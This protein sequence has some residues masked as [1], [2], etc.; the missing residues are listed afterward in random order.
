MNDRPHQKQRQ[1]KYFWIAFWLTLAVLV[2]LYTWAQMRVGKLVKTESGEIL[3]SGTYARNWE[4][5]LPKLIADMEDYFG[6]AGAEISGQIDT[7]IDAAFAPVYRQIPKFAD[8][9]YSVT[10]EY[11]EM[12][13]ALA[14]HLSK[15]LQRILFDETAFQTHLQTSEQQIL[16]VSQA[17]VAKALARTGED[18][19]STME[20][21]NQDM[22]IIS[23]VV[24]ISLE[25]AKKRFGDQYATLRYVGTATGA[26]ATAALTA[27]LMGKKAATK[28]ATKLAAKGAIKT[29]TIA[30]GAGTGALAGSWGGPVGAAIGGIIGAAVTWFATDKLIITIDEYLNREQFEKEITT[31]LDKEKAAIKTQLITAYQTQL[32]TLLKHNREGLQKN[33]RTTIDLIRK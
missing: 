10:G 2:V 33:I 28:L 17:I 11:S 29:A 20:F 25:D 7:R 32:N 19:K 5:A 15:D 8:F 24:A 30:G 14:G 26:A 23:E 22:A 13:T 16:E 4:Q 1:G 3:L 9:H 6:E 21:S 18:I 31:L 12:I 27:K